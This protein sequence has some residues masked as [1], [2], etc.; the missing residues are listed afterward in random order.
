MSRITPG[1]LRGLL[2]GNPLVLL[3]TVL[4]GVVNLIAPLFDPEGRFQI[5]VGRLWSRLLI[6]IG[7][8]KLTVEGLEK[9]DPKGS[10]VFASNHRSFMDTPVVLGQIP[11]QFRFLA[12]SGLFKVP[13]LGYHM[14]RAG[15]ISVHREDPR[16]ALKTMAEAARIIR[17]RGISVLVFPE[18]SRSVNGLRRFKEG[19]AY[20]AIKAGVPIVPVAI[21]G[22]PEVL[23]HNSLTMRPGKVRL[24]IGDPIPTGNLSLADRASLTEQVRT[25][26]AALLGD[27]M[28][29]PA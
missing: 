20:I 18:G 27:P 24:A 9:I 6:P 5:R 17:E 29:T 11:V 22:T 26:V 14:K 21:E 28:Q 12:K 10:Y 13:F 7:G 4:L 8:V 23:P 15:H 3:V 1:Y 16:S 19:A 2:I 25:R